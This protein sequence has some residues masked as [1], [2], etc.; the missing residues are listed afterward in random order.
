MAQLL[1]GL[2]AGSHL[3]LIMAAADGDLLGGSTAEAGNVEKCEEHAV[4]D[5]EPFEG[6]EGLGGGGWD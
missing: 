6:K 2:P 4:V 3:P 1:A 5:A